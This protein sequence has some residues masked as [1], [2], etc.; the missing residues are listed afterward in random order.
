MIH[1]V[2]TAKSKLYNGRAYSILVV[3]N[4]EVKLEKC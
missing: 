4:L 3:E 1:E 2:I